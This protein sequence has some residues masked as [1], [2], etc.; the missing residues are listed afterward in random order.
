MQYN[1]YAVHR[2]ARGVCSVWGVQCRVCAVYTACAEYVVAVN[3]MG[4]G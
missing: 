4:A 3:M 1:G 2:V